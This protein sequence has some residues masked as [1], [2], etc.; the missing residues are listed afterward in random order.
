MLLSSVPFKLIYE[1]VEWWSQ[2]SYFSEQTVRFTGLM[3]FQMKSEL[4]MLSAR[5]WNMS[6]FPYK[7]V[8]WGKW[9]KT[10]TYLWQKLEK[11]RL[12]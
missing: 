6:F 11:G 2:F 5:F 8:P 12:A 9:I 4:T 7:C 10:S 3:S 1:A